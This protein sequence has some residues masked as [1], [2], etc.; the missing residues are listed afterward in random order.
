MDIAAK[1]L[2]SVPNMNQPI[3]K[4]AWKKHTKAI[5]DAAVNVSN[6]SMKTT[7]LEVKKYLGRNASYP[8]KDDLLEEITEVRVT[9]HGTCG[10][11]EFLSRQGLVDICPEETG[12]V[13][14]VILKTNCFKT[15]SN[16]K[17]QW[18]H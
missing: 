7:A 5:T 8:R 2:T 9:V 12:K 11:R 3:S 6:N 1:R 16:I 13:I 4:V 14:D 15:C 17:S 18:E 10:S